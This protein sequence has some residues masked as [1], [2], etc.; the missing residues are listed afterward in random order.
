MSPGRGA[1]FGCASIRLTNEHHRG[2]PPPNGLR[3]HIELSRIAG[4]IVT[5]TYQIA[6]RE[7]DEVFQDTVARVAEALRRLD[8]WR[9]GLPQD[10]QV[11]LDL[12]PEIQIPLDDAPPNEKRLPSD[13]ALCMLHMKWNQVSQITLVTP[14]AIAAP[15]RATLPD[16]FLSTATR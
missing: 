10:L 7:N 3:A 8:D 5:E 11:P 6:P 12:P 16:A 14:P 2:L 9:E 15:P 13:R 4:Y 1:S